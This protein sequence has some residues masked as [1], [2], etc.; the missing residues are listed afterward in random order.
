MAAVLAGCRE[1]EDGE[2]AALVGRSAIYHCVSRVVDRRFILGDE[3]KGRF[4]T[5]L[6]KLERFSGVRVL[7]YCLMDNHFHVLLQVPEPE[8][9]TVDE[10]LERVRAL[11]GIEIMN[12]VTR[13]LRAQGRTAS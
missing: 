5:I 2:L 13:K 3:Q 1:L 8:E 12:G 6:R 9:L 10:I 11:H 7:T 4:M